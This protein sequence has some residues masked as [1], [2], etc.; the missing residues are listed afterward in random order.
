MTKDN[1][2]EQMNSSP[3]DETQALEELQALASL[4]GF[5][6]ALAQV[7]VANSYFVADDVPHASNRLTP[8]ELTLAA[9]FGA[10]KSLDDTV[11]P[12]E[13]ELNGHINALNTL[14]EQIHDTVK[15]QLE[16]LGRGGN[17][18]SR[19]FSADRA[20]EPA[21]PPRKGE[22]VEPL[23]YAGM[24]SCDFQHLNLAPEKYAQDTGWIK[25]NVG[26]SIESM[27][28]AAKELQDLREYRLA[29][30]FLASTLQERSRAAVAALTFTRDDLSFLTESEF[31]VFLDRFSVTP[32]HLALPVNAVGD[33]NDLEIKPIIRLGEGRFFMPVGFMLAKAIYESPNYWMSEDNDYSDDAAKHRGDATETIAYRLLSSVFGDSAH[34]NV[35]VCDGKRRVGEIDVLVVVGNRA[36]IVEAKAKRLTILSRKGSGQKLQEDFSLAVQGAYEQARDNRQR[37]LA[38]GFNVLASDG[39]PIQLPPAFKEVYVVCLT[40]DHIPALPYLVDQLLEKQSNDPYPVVMSVFGLDLVTTYLTDSIQLMHYIYQRATWSDRHFGTWE[41]QLLARYLQRGLALPQDSIRIML[42][43]GSSDDVE[44]HFM[45]LRGRHDLIHRLYWDGD[46][47]LGIGKLSTRWQETGLTPFLDTLREHPD[48]QSTDALFLLLDQPE[49][50]LYDLQRLIQRAVQDCAEDGKLAY[51]YCSLNQKSGVSVACFPESFGTEDERIPALAFALK[52]KSKADVWV[53]FWL[54]LGELGIGA[55]F[56]DKPWEASVELDESVRRFLHPDESV[57]ELKMG[58][59]CWCGSGELYAKCHAKGT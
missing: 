37:L 42:P 40:L 11:M 58:D 3:L 49:S 34:R 14:L 41:G 32:G 8:Q 57:V 59:P 55:G 46:T 21:E 1:R 23:N 17:H 27:V 12:S 47:E 20:N 33:V 19:R 43:E 38:G 9:A 10:K 2:S 15:H 35:E 7:S 53:A 31:N 45:S 39:T 18:P 13:E 28:R 6:Y 24:G 54:V 26:L 5:I 22:M 56:T 30:F 4:P 51:G 50:S 29:R 36:L 25:A 16:T 48:P 52:H 44:A